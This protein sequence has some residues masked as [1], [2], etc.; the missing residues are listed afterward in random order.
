MTVLL[1]GRDDVSLEAFTRVAWRGEGVE[2]A[3][4]ALARMTAC[5]REFLALLAADPSLSVYGVTTGTGEGAGA[6]LAPAARAEA[7]TRAPVNGSSFGEPLPER[8]VRG[9]VLARL[10]TFIEGN[11]AVR[12][13]LARAVGALLDG[14]LPEVP[15]RGNG[16][17]GEIVALGHLF[18]GIGIP[19]E[20]K[21]PIALIN[22][23]PCAAALTAD[24]VLLAR[25]RAARSERIFSLAVEAIAAPLGAFA[26]ELEPLWDD[27]AET[28]VLRSL[29]ELLAGAV[30]DRRPY[31]APVSF[32]IL[33]RLL[34]DMGV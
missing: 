32:R 24:G 34:A 14:P 4:A 8:V 1:A 29:R 2:L 7:A 12:P 17:A 27:P 30:A 21:E 22:G 20:L 10:T 28:A 26:A 5:R 16:G 18:H 6:L 23:S 13:E 33:P 11:A 31:Q 19:L 9:I 15:A 25:A 3:P